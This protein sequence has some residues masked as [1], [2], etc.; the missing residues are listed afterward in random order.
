VV[1]RVD[2]VVASLRNV[3]DVVIVE[4]PSFVDVH[5][6]EGLAPSVDVIVVVAESRA[7][8]SDRLQ[9]VGLS[10]KRLG[11]PVVGVVLT[12]I[13]APIRARSTGRTEADAP[14]VDE[15]LD[16]DGAAAVGASEL[17]RDHASEPTGTDGVPAGR[18]VS[19][20]GSA[21]GAPPTDPDR[22]GD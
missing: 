22:P 1:E 3:V 10:L 14:S 19:G 15:D 5:H 9:S 2:A 4:V 17:E 7:T 13:D 12:G 8:R 18:D 20:G 21:P 6:G 11:A 16:D